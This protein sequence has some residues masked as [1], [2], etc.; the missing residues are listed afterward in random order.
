MR[1]LLL[2]LLLITLVGC[3][4]DIEA[5]LEALNVSGAEVVTDGDGQVTQISLADT[6]ITNAG[7]EHLKGLTNLEGLWLNDTQVTDDGV[8]ELQQ[9]FLSCVVTR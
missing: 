5:R 7:L 9:S 1:L 6:Q 4:V 2:T 8:A 3:G